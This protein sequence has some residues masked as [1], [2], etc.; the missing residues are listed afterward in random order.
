[1]ERQQLV[2]SQ[3]WVPMRSFRIFPFV[4]QLGLPIQTHSL[5]YLMPLRQ[6]SKLAGYSQS[7][8]KMTYVLN[9]GLGPISKDQ[10]HAQIKGSRCFTGYFDES[11]N[12]VVKQGQMDLHVRFF[13]SKNRLITTF[14]FNAVFFE[15]SKA[16]DLLEHFKYGFSGM[17]FNKI[18][19]VSMDGP[20]A[21][22]SFF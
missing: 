6:P 16:Q 5:S 8:T 2:V 17:P 20:N 19:Q 9:Y 10:M 14:Y 22:W 13:D 1:M 4:P 21:N 3:E 18:I 7:S 12:R 15:R 11:L